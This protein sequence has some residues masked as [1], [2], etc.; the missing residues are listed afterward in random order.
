[1]TTLQ[2]VG[3]ELGGLVVEQMGTLQFSG[4]FCGQ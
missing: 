2:L 1:V 4:Q 3:Q